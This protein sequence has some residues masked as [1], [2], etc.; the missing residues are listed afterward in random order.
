MCLHF[1]KSQDH[2]Y[3]FSLL[4]LKNKVSVQ[5]E[6]HAVLN[7]TCYCAIQYIKCCVVITVCLC[8]LISLN[9]QLA[10]IIRVAR[11]RIERK[12][13]AVSF[14]TLRKAV[15]PVRHI[16]SILGAVITTNLS[17]IV[18]VYPERWANCNIK[19][20]TLDSNGVINMSNFKHPV[21]TSDICVRNGLYKLDRPGLSNAF[22]DIS[23]TIMH[24]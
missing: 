15:Q 16:G 2:T 4:T 10:I 22:Y 12:H 3:M 6:I 24:F 7:S 5:N 13:R 9:V 23:Y 21:L 11:V 19:N 17:P 20:K 1:F 18:R 8:D 14:Q